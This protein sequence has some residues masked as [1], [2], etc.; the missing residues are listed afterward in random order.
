MAQLE[1]IQPGGGNPSPAGKKKFQLNKKNIVLFGGIGI[2]A[3][4]LIAAMLKKST[5][6]DSQAGGVIVGED[7]M[8]TN[9]A[10]VAAQLQGYN[11]MI[12]SD[13]NSQM[14]GLASMVDAN[15]QQVLNDMTGIITQTTQDY[16][17]KLDEYQEKFQAM[18]E[19]NKSMQDSFTE[20]LAAQKLQADKDLAAARK[21]AADDLAKYK[22][23]D[24]AAAK[25]AA[26]QSAKEIKAAKE[27]AAKAEA[28]AKKALAKKTPAKKTTTKK[29]TSQHLNTKTSIVD[30]LK[31]SGKNSSFAA[32]KKLASRMGIRNYRGTAAQNTK[33][34]STLKKRK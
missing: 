27:R 17:E 23:E 6:G 11:D 4:M 3:F 14:S 8:P 7:G 24:T 31:A 33:M 26:A 30:Y 18:E 2:V 15:N 21:K 34:L 10:D 32:R 13:V 12:S 20:Q 19:S 29:T 5:G 16:Q 25:K 1:V 22:K 28:A 9:S